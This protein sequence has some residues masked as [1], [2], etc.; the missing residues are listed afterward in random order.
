MIYEDAVLSAYGVVMEHYRN[1][2]IGLQAWLF[3]ITQIYKS[4]MKL[5]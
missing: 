1:T 4:D 3:M 5:N 2:S